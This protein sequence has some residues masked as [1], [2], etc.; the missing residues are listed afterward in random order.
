MIDIRKLT[1]DYV[2][3]FDSRNLDKVGSFFSE[4]FEL[5]D[6]D[7][8]AITPKNTVMTYIKKL[9]DAHDNL[10]FE[11]HNII[12]DG[13]TSVIHFTLTLGSLVLDGADII[14]WQSGQ[15]I[16]MKAYLSPRK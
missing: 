9:F 4:D 14:T 8:T 16:R 7:V 10:N 6:P 2:A 1:S 11:A 5:T 12:V 3:A 15:M 13:N